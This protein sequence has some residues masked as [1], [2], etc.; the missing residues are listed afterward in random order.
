MG[1]RAVAVAGVGERFI[2]FYFLFRRCCWGSLFH[3]SGPVFGLQGPGELETGQ[4]D[5]EERA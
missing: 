4:P 5:N 3:V 1:E 2:Y